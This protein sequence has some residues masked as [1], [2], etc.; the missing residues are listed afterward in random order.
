[1][2]KHTPY[3]VHP[4]CTECSTHP[5]FWNLP[6]AGFLSMGGEDRDMKAG[7]TG[8]QERVAE[9]ALSKCPTYVIL[10]RRWGRGGRSVYLF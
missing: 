7:E 2:E 4:G 3:S 1:M 8:G 6:P 5:T 10:G 9:Q